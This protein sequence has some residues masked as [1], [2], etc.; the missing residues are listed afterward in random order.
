[1]KV[2]IIAFIFLIVG[3]NIGYLLGAAVTVKMLSEHIEEGDVEDV[4]RN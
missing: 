4:K 2:V 3:A 1:M